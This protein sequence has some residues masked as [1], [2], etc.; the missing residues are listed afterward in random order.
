MAIH[1]G[2]QILGYLDNIFSNP[3]TDTKY[4]DNKQGFGLLVLDKYDIASKYLESYYL[5][6]QEEIIGY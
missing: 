1:S 4:F 5:M 2:Q 6:T 3:K